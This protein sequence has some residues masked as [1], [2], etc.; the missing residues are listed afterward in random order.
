[1]DYRE[2]E[3]RRLQAEREHKKRNKKQQSADESAGDSDA[4]K[5]VGK[6]KQAP[7]RPYSPYT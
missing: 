7:I 6:R 5:R 4:P 2:Q 1:L 3:D